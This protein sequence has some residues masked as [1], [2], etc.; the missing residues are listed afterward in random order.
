MSFLNILEN[1]YF[2]EDIAPYLKYECLVNLYKI[3]KR[4][5]IKKWLMNT[6]Q[7]RC[8]IDS[9][10]DAFQTL[11]DVVGF[12]DQWMINNSIRIVKCIE[13]GHQYFHYDNGYLYNNACCMWRTCPH[14]NA[15][16]CDTTNCRAFCKRCTYSYC[17]R[18]YVSS[19]CY[20]SKDKKHK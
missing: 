13:C 4:N 5:H 14:C 1:P 20:L 2:F 16:F 19:E 7:K 8:H 9:N 11:L 10:I 6:I 18:C 3:C 15:P 12:Y 17:K